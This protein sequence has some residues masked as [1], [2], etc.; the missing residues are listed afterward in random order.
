MPPAQQLDI[1]ADSPDVAL[2]NDVILALEQRDGAAAQ[3]AVWAL[4][5]ACPKDPRRA[6]FE[7]LADH[8]AATPETPL[9]APSEVAAERQ[10]LE[11]EIQPAAQVA[12]DAAAARWMAQAWQALARRSGPVPFSPA[13][14]DDHAAAL[15]LRGGAWSEAAEA[16][17]RVDSWRR[18]P[19]PLAWHLEALCRMGRLEAAWPLLA[20]LA[21]MAPARLS[22]VMARLHDPL[23]QRLNK[24]FATRFEGQ[25]TA[26]DLA[27]FPAWLLVDQPALAA[28]LGPA[29]PGQHTAPE[30]AMRLMLELLGLERQGR[31]AE[32][33]QRRRALKDLHGPLYAAY[34]ATR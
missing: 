3:R 4:V 33:L 30:R 5:A 14:A 26:D 21:W 10:R 22:V 23:L 9:A 34:M 12:L 8:L 25:G 24:Q 18:I 20:E 15:W 7:C 17:E 6:P 2:R 11:A 29:Q 13:H 16:A 32:L 31:H 28:H 27:W 19:A 1:F